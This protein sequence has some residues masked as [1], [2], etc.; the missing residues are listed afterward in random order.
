[1]PFTVSTGSIGV[2]PTVYWKP[3]LFRPTGMIFDLEGLIWLI[4]S[5]H[6]LRYD[7]AIDAMSLFEG[8]MTVAI[9]SSLGWD[10][11]LTFTPWVLRQ[12]NDVLPI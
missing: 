5:L 6:S 2:P 7:A 1:M 3:G 10:A 4:R 8:Y 12:A 9:P 11:K